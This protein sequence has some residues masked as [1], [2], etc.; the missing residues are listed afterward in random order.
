METSSVLTGSIQKPSSS[1]MTVRHATASRAACYEEVTSLQIVIVTLERKRH[2]TGNKVTTPAWWISCVQ[3]METVKPLPINNFENESS[4]L[5]FGRLLASRK[6][7]V[8]PLC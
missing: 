1:V 5:A 6:R 3:N 4:K 8:R 2:V 7:I